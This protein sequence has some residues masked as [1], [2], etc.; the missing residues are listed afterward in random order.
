MGATL[1]WLKDIPM[2]VML[3]KRLVGKLVTQTVGKMAALL[4]HLKVDCLV[5]EMDT[6]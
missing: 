3:G 2:V 4:E 1:E 5:V 6:K